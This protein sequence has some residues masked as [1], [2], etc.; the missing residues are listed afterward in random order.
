[1]VSKSWPILQSEGSWRTG[2]INRG[3]RETTT[4]R[5]NSSHSARPHIDPGRTLTQQT[6]TLIA[7]QCVTICKSSA[8]PFSW[9]MRWPTVMMIL[10][11]FH[12]V[13]TASCRPDS[14]LWFADLACELIP[15]QQCYLP[16]VRLI[17][18][19]YSKK[20]S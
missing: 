17:W 9:P 16:F 8:P 14:S 3:D 15:E 13:R 7:T 20:I 6:L 5:P 1:M 19:K 4:L 10:M 12:Q 2:G 18:T 11:A